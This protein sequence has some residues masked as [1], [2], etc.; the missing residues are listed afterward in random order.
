V[1]S[2]LLLSH[3]Y[4]QRVVN[5]ING[6][7]ESSKPKINSHTPQSVLK[8]LIS[9]LFVVIYLTTS[10]LYQLIHY[11]KKVE[12]K[13]TENLSLESNEYFQEFVY[14]CVDST[15][16]TTTTSLKNPQPT[17]PYLPAMTEL[18]AKT[19][20]G[21]V[22]FRLAWEPCPDFFNF[23][24]LIVSDINFLLCSAI[25]VLFTFSVK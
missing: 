10:P 3:K 19:R 20:A 14:Y 17:P 25:Q 12:R 8:P 24:S 15:T 16:T 9:S 21:Y 6:D 4:P 1:A 23:I 7:D 13:K 2:L 11:K 5:F 22:F 18:E